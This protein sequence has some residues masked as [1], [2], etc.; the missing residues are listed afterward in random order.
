M[1]ND[2]REDTKTLNNILEKIYT[3]ANCTINQYLEKER[4]KYIKKLL[5]DRSKLEELE[6][7]TNSIHLL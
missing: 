1:L 3:R 4:Y 2:R 7:I 6:L 5:N